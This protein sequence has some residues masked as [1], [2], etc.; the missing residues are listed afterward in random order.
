MAEE[1]LGRVFYAR[2]KWGVRIAMPEKHKRHRVRIEK[3]TYETKD[4]RAFIFVPMDSEEG[5]FSYMP[6]QFFVLESQVTRPRTFVY[7]KSK[8]TMV[9]IG[10][11]ATVV[12]KR[13]FS[14]VSSPAEHEYI[15]L[16]LKSEEGLF[17]PYFLDEDKAGNICTLIGPQGKF[18]HNLLE[19]K[20]KLIACWSSGSGIASTISL[21][22]YTLDMGLDSKIIVFDSNRTEDDII[23]YERIKRLVS[24]SEN[25]YAVF[26]D[27]KDNK[28]PI[29]DHPRIFYRSGRFWVNG[30]NP[31]EKYA[32]SNWRDYFN[33]ICGS[34]SFING[35]TRDKQGRSVK[36]GKGIEDHLLEAGIPQSR[37][38]KDQFYLL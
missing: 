13:A 17:V 7:D 23:F 32:G 30:E 27:T 19:N 14:I 10:E 35:R 33:T 20:E 29:S 21:M 11:T 4:S 2:Q 16:L 12:D 38:E 3:I 9:G 26:T 28:I 1:K 6:G 36:L 34:S 22:Q 24:E 18:M 25:F 15:E 31:L 8:G 37:I 5:L